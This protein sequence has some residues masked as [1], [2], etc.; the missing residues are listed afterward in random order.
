MADDENYAV[1]TMAAL[2]LGQ[3]MK[4]AISQRETQELLDRLVDDGWLCMSPDGGSYVMDNRATMELQGYL[5]EQYGDVIKECL[6]CYEVITMGERCEL[7]ACPVRI[8]RHC[9]DGY[10]RDRQQ[11]VIACPQC[12]TTWSR[13]NTF[14]L[15]L[16]L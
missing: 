15:G 13:H 7:Q 5:R 14:G 9:A 16:P 11:S 12:S 10:F 8:H 3:K 4:P 6:V 1:S 2:R